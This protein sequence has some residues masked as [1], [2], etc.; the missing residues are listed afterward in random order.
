M[1]DN[2]NQNWE[3]AFHVMMTILTILIVIGILY[4]L[5]LGIRY[6]RRANRDNQHLGRFEPVRALPPRDPGYYYYDGNSFVKCAQPATN[7]YA[8]GEVTYSNPLYPV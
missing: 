3:R 7:P 5:Y 6:L 2:E 4:L 1:E 8:A